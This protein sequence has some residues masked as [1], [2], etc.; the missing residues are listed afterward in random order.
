MAKGRFGGET[1][2]PKQLGPEPANATTAAAV[3]MPAAPGPSEP[4]RPLVPPQIALTGP[5]TRVLSDKIPFS[6]R[7]SPAVQESLSRL[8]ERTGRPVTHLLDEALADLFAK[9]T[10]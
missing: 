6:S 7:I 5:R 4:A 1:Y 2:K 8:V 3:D 9:H 10:K